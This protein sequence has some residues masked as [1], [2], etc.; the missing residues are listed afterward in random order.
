MSN[1]NTVS[2]PTSIDQLKEYA[3]GTVVE[4]P[5]FGEGQRFFVRLRRPSLM[6]LA[7]TG[8]IPNQLL[9]KAS[10]MFASGANALN[11][12]DGNMLSEVYDIMH[13]IAD[14]SMVEPTLADIEE[15]GVSMTDE[16]MMAVFSYT[17]NG[18]SALSQFRQQ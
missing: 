3:D 6:M 17:Q 16:Q 15:A 1:K 12:S 18:V 9:A 2:T 10:E 4:L 14:A 11:D 7:K 5:P 13:S 8:K